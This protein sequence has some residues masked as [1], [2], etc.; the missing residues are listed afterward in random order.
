M[1]RV[2][3]M[4]ERSRKIGRTDENAIN[5]FDFRN[6]FELVEGGT[7]LNLYE[8]ANFIICLGEIARHATVPARARGNRDTTKALRRVPPWR[9]G[10]PGL[11]PPLY[12]RGQEKP[13]A[14]IE[15]A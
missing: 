15:G 3:E 8:H 2:P 9:G 1:L 5:P 7:R 4:A 13:R 6:C 12:T 11:L 14:D 10:A